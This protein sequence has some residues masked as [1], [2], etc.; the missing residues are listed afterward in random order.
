MCADSGFADQ[1]AFAVFE[2]NLKI[3]YVV[4]SKIY[5]DIKESILKQKTLLRYRTKGVPTN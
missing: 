1:K 5:T 4:T 3:H 2:D